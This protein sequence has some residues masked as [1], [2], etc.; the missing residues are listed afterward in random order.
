MFLIRKL[1]LCGLLA[2]AF[3]A[4]A[5]GPAGGCEK[6]SQPAYNGGVELFSP[7]F[8]KTAQWTIF[9]EYERNLLLLYAQQIHYRGPS[10]AIL[11]QNEIKDQ[12]AYVQGIVSL[13]NNSRDPRWRT[14]LRSLRKEIAA[15]PRNAETTALIEAIDR[16]QL[17]LMRHPPAPRHTPD[18]HGFILSD[19]MEFFAYVILTAVS[20]RFRNH[21]L[22][23]LVWSALRPSLRRALLLRAEAEYDSYAFNPDP[24]GL[25]IVKKFIIL[26]KNSGD[27]RW[28]SFLRLFIALPRSIDAELRDSLARRATEALTRL[29]VETAQAI[30]EIINW[31]IRDQNN[32]RKKLLRY[33]WQTLS[34]DLQDQIIA[35]AADLNQYDIA[36]KRA[37]R[38]FIDF[39]RYSR[40]ERWRRLLLTWR[41]SLNVIGENWQRHLVRH[42]DLAVASIDARESDPPDSQGRALLL[43]RF[44]SFEALCE[45]IRTAARENRVFLG[46]HAFDRMN[47]RE[48]SEGDILRAL[49]HP[50]G[51]IVRNDGYDDVRD[52]FTLKWRT[53]A[54][55]VVIGYPKKGTLN[56]VAVVTTFIP[57]QQEDRVPIIREP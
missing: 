27:L 46:D 23:T 3:P 45:Q 40:E 34:P 28:A 14:I 56:D 57:E 44:G 48:I 42:I 50:N 49:R 8:F 6:Q 53:G 25:Q 26:A 24:S 9:S 47:E 10:D 38:V 5:Q 43:D 30:R 33:D 19:R 4:L 11:F 31:S 7:A 16:S 36:N 13:A 29:R 15:V 18:A 54:I 39:A 55:E 22:S 52:N 37:L 20:D 17:K 32:R 12:L 21:A 2:A 51:T 35:H 1:L 41:T